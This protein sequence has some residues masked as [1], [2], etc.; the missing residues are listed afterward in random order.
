MLLGNNFK[1]RGGLKFKHQFK[2]T[3]KADDPSEFFTCKGNSELM[4]MKGSHQNDIQ[5]QHDGYPAYREIK[6]LTKRDR[7]TEGYGI[8]NFP[9]S[10]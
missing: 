9:I 2:E 4:S 6:A 3:K 1:T 8:S 7:L 5:S 10:L